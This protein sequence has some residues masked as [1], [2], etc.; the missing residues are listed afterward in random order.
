MSINELA[1]DEDGEPFSVPA[2]VTGLRVRRAL[3]GRGRPC[4]CIRKESHW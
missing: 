2:D 4:W 1:I 3:D